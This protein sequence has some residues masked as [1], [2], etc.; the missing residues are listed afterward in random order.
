M[1]LCFFCRSHTY[2]HC[3][4][5]LGLF[6]LLYL[7]CS[8]WPIWAPLL[9][10]HSRP[11][12]AFKPLI[13]LPSTSYLSLCTLTT[14][15]CFWLFFY[16][17]CFFFPMT[18]SGFFNG[19][20]GVSEARALNFYTLFRLI[21]L[22]LFASR[23]LT[24]IYLPLSG[25]LDSLLCD[26]IAPTP[27]LIFFLLMPHTL[28]AASSFL[29]GRSS[30]FSEHSTSSLSSLDPVLR[31]TLSYVS[32]NISL[33]NSSSFSFLGAYAPPIHCSPRDSRIDSF[34]PS[35]FPIFRNLFILG[36]CNY[37]HHH[38]DSK[39][40]SDPV[41]NNR[42]SGSRSSSDISFD[43]SSL[44]SERC[45][46]T[47][48]LIS[49]KFSKSSLLLRSF[50]ST[51]VPLHLIFSKLVGMTLL[52]ILTVTVLLQSPLMLLSLIF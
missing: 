46:R 26:V 3:D 45:F 30:P 37:H 38:W 49:Y 10:Q 52:F 24:L 35:I 16:T 41:G 28:A 19:M 29:S 22:T 25:F 33:N 15:P 43:P 27:S 18:L 2:Q 11:I 1:H 17:S 40:I 39:G 12:L 23:N 20:L 7:H 8:I 50:A 44:A 21:P 48:I 14:A 47:W 31:L 42:S 6:Q 32:V 4:F 13:L 9:L 51:N 36:D 5:L 34:S